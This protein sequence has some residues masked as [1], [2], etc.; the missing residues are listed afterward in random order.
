MGFRGN[1]QFPLLKA[2]VTHFFPFFDFSSSSSSIYLF[3]KVVCVR[4]SGGEFPIAVCFSAAA[5]AEA[6]RE[7]KKK[8]DSERHK[9]KLCLGIAAF[10]SSPL[11][12]VCLAKKKKK[13]NAKSNSKNSFF[14]FPTGFSIS[15]G[16]RTGKKNFSS[17]PLM[18]SKLVL[19]LFPLLLSFVPIWEIR[20]VAGESK[21][22]WWTSS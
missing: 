21:K 13:E 15:L 10:V 6:M 12:L 14:P 8:S 17:F 11:F 16:E 5:A 2:D 9:K 1:E 4:R 19:F 20:R 22:R 18:G 3:A 7:G